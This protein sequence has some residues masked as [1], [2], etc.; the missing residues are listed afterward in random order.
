MEFGEVKMSD[1][2]LLD[3]ADQAFEQ[4][5]HQYGLDLLRKFS[6]TK[7]SDAGS[8]HRL[9]VVEEQIGDVVAAGNAHYQCI[10]RAPQIALGYLYAAYWLQ[11]TGKPDAAASLYSLAEEADPASL[12]E[13][14]QTSDQNRIR[15]DSG[16]R[17]LNQFL[18]RQ[19]RS[20]FDDNAQLQRIQNAIWPR[21]HDS[22]FIYPE[23][24]FKPELFYLPE[25][26]RQKYYQA[27][28]F[29]WAELV[30][31]LAPNIKTEL[32]NA[33]SKQA[34]NSQLRPYLPANSV[35]QGDLKDLSGSMDWSALDLFKNGVKNQLLADVFPSTFRLIESLPLYSL[36]HQPFEVFFSLLRPQQTIKSH[37]GQSNHAL[38]VHLPLTVPENCFLEVAGEKHHWRE[39]EL[40]VFDDSFKH[41]AYNQ[42]EQLR[43]VMIFSIWH[44]DLN[45]EE[46]EAIQ[47]SFRIRQQWMQER[48]TDIAEL[49]SPSR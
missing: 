34:A 18:S 14:L 5:K 23:K 39:N 45:I 16:R 46:R 30:V 25:I 22:S 8:W 28:E 20:L 13:K 12:Q 11:K 7:S 40:V 38:T 33:L 48:A 3:A 36:E 31:K 19:H 24:S 49:V 9:A 42:S 43:I 32:I 10:E 6:H 47:Q 2:E 29:D 15:A 37:Y 17:W 44:P 41:S 35:T 21:T 26:R 27:S 1:L 4:G